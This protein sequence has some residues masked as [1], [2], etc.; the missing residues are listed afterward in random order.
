M[1]Y[2]L[3]HT[4]FTASCWPSSTQQLLFARTCSRCLINIYCNF[5]CCEEYSNIELTKN[6]CIW[7][8]KIKIELFIHTKVWIILYS[9]KVRILPIR[10]SMCVFLSSIL[11]CQ[12]FLWDWAQGLAAH[13]LWFGTHVKHLGQNFP[14]NL[15]LAVSSR[16][17]LI[18]GYHLFWQV[19]LAFLL[20][21]SFEDVGQKCNCGHSEVL[22]ILE[23]P[24]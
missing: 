6:F 24:G 1:S 17:V 8:R 22:S 21:K 3:H 18:N 7:Y 5:E 9:Y 10:K 16:Y 4:W 11:F 2:H 13:H 20:A 19:F 12:I 14:K 23:Y 15:I